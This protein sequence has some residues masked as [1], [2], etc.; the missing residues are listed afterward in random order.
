M[1]DGS[2][3]IWE[4]LK[5]LKTALA[6]SE[7]EQL[8][9]VDLGLTGVQIEGSPDQIT[10]VVG[11]VEI[12]ADREISPVRVVG[13]NYNLSLEVAMRVYFKDKTMKTL[14]ALVDT[15]A[16]V[17]LINR[18]LV[19]MD[20]WGD[21]VPPIRFR[22]AN[23]T[24]LPGGERAVLVKLRM[25]GR[26]EVQ[27]F[28]TSEFPAL[29]YG[30]EIQA[31]MILSYSWLAQQGMAVVASENMMAWL[32]GPVLMMV[33]GLKVRKGFKSLERVMTGVVVDEEGEDWADVE[34]WDVSLPGGRDEEVVED[35]CEVPV[36]LVEMVEELRLWELGLEV[37][38]EEGLRIVT[39]LT[40]EELPEVTKWWTMDV[41]EV[42][43]VVQ[44]GNPLEMEEVE[45]KRSAIMRDYDGI[46]FSDVTPGDPPIRGPLGEAEI[47]LKPGAI[48]GKQNHSWNL[49]KEGMQ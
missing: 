40:D 11:P 13:K 38:D 44:V 39:G 31:D 23:Q 10:S 48:P 20:W 37:E 2:S 9:E 7:S 42:M 47:R 46:V 32:T 43:G 28:Y 25:K 19:N 17:S 35:G 22:A 12:L 33:D 49:V 5:Q 16:Q 15:G 4:R 34:Q 36:D 29:L 26:T 41:S 30:A 24:S 27:T 14:R 6:S 3:L 1:V 45:R 18:N 8:M 21:D